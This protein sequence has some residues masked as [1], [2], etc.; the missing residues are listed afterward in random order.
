[1]KTSEDVRELGLYT[2]DC[3][4]QDLIFD[5]GDTFCRCPKCMRL[6]EWELESRITPIEALETDLMVEASR[7]SPTCAA[8]A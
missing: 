5:V 3:C 8:V 2:S 1:M 7:Y 6:C 4:N